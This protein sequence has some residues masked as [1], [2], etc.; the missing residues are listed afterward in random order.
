MKIMTVI[1]PKAPP[2]QWDRLGDTALSQILVS[3]IGKRHGVRNNILITGSYE[4]TPLSEYISKYDPLQARIVKE[5]RVYEGKNLSQRDYY[6]YLT[7]KVKELEP[8]IVHVQQAQVAAS[9]YISKLATETQ[10]PVIWTLHNPPEGRATFQYADSYKEIL[11]NPLCRIVCVSNSA[12]DR[13]VRTLKLDSIPENLRVVY[14]GIEMPEPLSVDKEYDFIGVG[15][16]DP[17]KNTEMII[18]FMRAMSD[19]KCLFIG[20]TFST[21]NTPGDYVDRCVSKIESAPNIEWIKSVPHDQIYEYMAKSRFYVNLSRVETFS[22]TSCEAMSVGTPVICFN[23][24]GPGEIV[25][26]FAG[27][28]L[29]PTYRMRT[30]K[31]L[32]Y[33]EGEVKFLSPMYDKLFDPVKIREYAR[34]NFSSTS[35]YENYYKL[36]KELVGHD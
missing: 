30:S 34:T 1:N 31:Y 35:M 14:N 19:K 22:L 7:E 18:D 2:S 20:S 5:Y 16:I 21:Y 12:R 24:A 23:E 8:D 29:E 11:S 9:S 6:R 3:E 4:E 13:L 27:I 10:T 17:P 33:L 32:E 25:P 36:Y 26:K 28:K 15:R